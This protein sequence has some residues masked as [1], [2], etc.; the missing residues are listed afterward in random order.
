MRL[1]A[2][3]DSPHMVKLHT[4]TIVNVFITEPSCEAIVTD[5]SEVVDAVFTG[6]IVT[7]RR[8]C[9]VIDVSFTVLASKTKRT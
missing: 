9:A 4:L 7:Q 3:D 2:V 1:N 6:A 5:T 8:W